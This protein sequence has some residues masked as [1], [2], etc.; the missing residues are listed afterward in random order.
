MPIEFTTSKKVPLKVNFLTHAPSKAGKTHAL[1][2][3]E[4]VVVVASETNLTLAK[5]PKEIPMIL[6]RNGAD[7]IDA[8]RYLTESNE[9]RMF[10]NVATD[11]ASDICQRMLRWNK[12]NVSNKYD[13]YGHMQDDFMDYIRG[14][15]DNPN[16]SHYCTTR[17]ERYEVGEN[18]FMFRPALPGKFLSGQIDFE[19]D[20]VY[21][22]VR[23]PKERY[24][25]FSPPSNYVSGSRFDVLSGKG[26][27]D[28][29]AIFNHIKNGLRKL[30]EGQIVD[31][32]DP[33]KAGV[34]DEGFG[35]ITPEMREREAAEDSDEDT[36]NTENE[37]EEYPVYSEFC[38]TY[39]VGD[40]VIF[41]GN[42]MKIT[43]KDL[44]EHTKAL[45]VYKAE[46]KK[47]KQTQTK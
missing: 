34:I 29:Q 47:A 45:A 26:A 32:K 44:Q 35:T 41:Q 30:S 11:S 6:V 27:P 20:F 13:H 19:F 3:L 18:I 17:Q 42:A 43:K 37:K 28:L 8:K 22:L 33:T 46:Q 12:E 9:A 25:N 36:T 39:K 14:I 5:L 4:D 40:T 15:A 10:Q 16:L 21:P 2:T 24:F 23:T 38:E 31:E 7:L 1:A